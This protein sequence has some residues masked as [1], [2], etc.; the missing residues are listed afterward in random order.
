MDNALVGMFQC[1]QGEDI[2]LDIPC[3][4]EVLLHV[5]VPVFSQPLTQL[6]V[7]Q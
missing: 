4:Q 5:K 1:Q 2:V 3:E 6:G 7:S